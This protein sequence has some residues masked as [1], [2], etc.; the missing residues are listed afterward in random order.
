MARKFVLSTAAV[1]LAASMFSA[2]QAKAEGLGGV[3]PWQQCGIGAM[4]FPEHG[5]A[6]AISNIIWD[7]GTTAVTSATVSKET[8]EGAGTFTAVFVTESY[9]QIEEQ[10]AVGEGEHLNAMLQLMGC[11]AA[12]RPSA[13]QKLRADYAENMATDAFATQDQAQ[14]AEALYYTAANAVAACQAS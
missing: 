12:Q 3:N 1:V 11:N 14:K 5:L 13:I 8:C 10:L 7:L 2:P 9:V 4:I 6:A